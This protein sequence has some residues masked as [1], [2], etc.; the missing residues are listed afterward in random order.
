MVTVLLN[1][2]VLH[3][4]LRLGQ[5]AYPLSYMCRFLITIIILCTTPVLPSGDCR[6]IQPPSTCTRSSRRT[7]KTIVIVAVL[8]LQ[9][10]AAE[11]PPKP[12]DRLHYLFMY[13]TSIGLDLYA[14]L[15]DD[16]TAHAALGGSRPARPPTT[17]GHRQTHAPSARRRP[18]RAATARVPTLIISL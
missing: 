18:V 12:I 8:L 10:F 6:P 17:V 15:D 9:L 7:G 14:D 3:H 5:K 13:R 16:I 2:V 11:K 4:F 1:V